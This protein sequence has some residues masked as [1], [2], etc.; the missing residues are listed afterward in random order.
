MWRHDAF[1]ALGEPMQAVES[2]R[3]ES[4]I[5]RATAQISRDL[6]VVGVVVGSS[7]MHSTSV[8]SAARPSAGLFAA[9]TDRAETRRANLLW[10][11]I[12]L[13]VDVSEFE[14]RAAL[15][16]RIVR[17]FKLG[18]EGTAVLLVRGFRHAAA[19]STPSVAVI[20]I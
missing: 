2:Q 9:F 12:P 4:A 17:V 14:D 19:E 13:T 1:E 7:R 8:M 11:V 20:W 16:R 5:A 15:A 18:A 6:P 3:A 10:G